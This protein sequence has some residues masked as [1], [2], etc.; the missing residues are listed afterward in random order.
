MTLRLHLEHLEEFCPKELTVIHAFMVLAAMKGVDQH[1]K[2]SFQA[3]FL[4]Q[5]HT[6]MQTRGI[7]PATV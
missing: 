6:D 2:S 3:Q 4:A 1:I 5:G 7:G